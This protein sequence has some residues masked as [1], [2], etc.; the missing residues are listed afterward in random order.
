MDVCDIV[1]S[2]CWK[3]EGTVLEFQ[4]SLAVWRSGL[5]YVRIQDSALLPALA[6]NANPRNE[7]WE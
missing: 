5:K 3:A 4:R 1:V 6:A 2:F 7:V